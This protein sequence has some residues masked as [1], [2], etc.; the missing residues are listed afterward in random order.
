MVLPLSENSL[1]EAGS[2]SEPGME[3]GASEG[4]GMGDTKLRDGTDHESRLWDFK[5]TAPLPPAP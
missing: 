3:R 4:E 2:D 5:P 1:G